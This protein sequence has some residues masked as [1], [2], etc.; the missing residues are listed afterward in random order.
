[1]GDDAHTRLSHRLFAAVT[2]S[3][4][5]GCRPRTDDD[6]DL[7]TPGAGWATRVRGG[8]AREA[9]PSSARAWALAAAAAAT[10]ALAMSPVLRDRWVGLCAAALDAVG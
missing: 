8:V 4:N 5:C 1:M 7:A 3:C 10:A 2:G 9:A 6:A